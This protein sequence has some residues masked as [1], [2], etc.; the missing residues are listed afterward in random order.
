MSCIYVNPTPP[1]YILYQCC[2]AN[3]SNFSLKQ[4]CGYSSQVLIV[5]KFVLLICTTWNKMDKVWLRFG[6]SF[7]LT[8]FKIW[9][10]LNNK[11][12][13]GLNGNVQQDSCVEGK[14]NQENKNKTKNES[15]GH[16]CLLPVFI[17][18]VYCLLN[19]SLHGLF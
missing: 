7:T 16:Q 14:R 6:N 4:F 1:F 18:P 2:L 15:K 19:W 8:R 9:R 5:G 17:F 11:S 12:F 3:I 13:I 10:W